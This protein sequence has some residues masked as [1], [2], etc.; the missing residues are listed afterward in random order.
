MAGHRVPPR[1]YFAIFAALMV[2]T[3]VTVTAAF[4]NLGPLNTI[5]A[6]TIA[7]I[8]ALLVVL[9]FMHL[10]YSERLTWLFAG[11][12]VAWLMILLALTIS[13]YLSRSL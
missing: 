11:A 7:V 6:M 5:V 1:I 2:L 4:F 9:Y 12:G 10:R 8:K 13:D 3:A